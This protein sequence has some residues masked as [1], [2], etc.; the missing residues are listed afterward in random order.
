MLSPLILVNE[1]K[2]ANFERSFVS[3]PDLSSRDQNWGERIWIEGPVHPCLARSGRPVS[4]VCVPMNDGQA[5][6]LR[7]FMGTRLQ[8]FL[9]IQKVRTSHEQARRPAVRM[10]R[11]VSRVVIEMGG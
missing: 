5:K 2:G 1:V 10:P 3:R 7:Y 11:A 6:S 4:R 9:N 8:K